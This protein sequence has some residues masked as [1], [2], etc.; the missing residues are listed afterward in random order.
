MKSILAIFEDR[1][2]FM[3]NIEVPYPPPTFWELAVRRKPVKVGLRMKELTNFPEE[4]AMEKLEFILE[5]NNDLLERPIYK[6]VF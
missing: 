2:G 4:S 6:E 5:N 1:K 3:K